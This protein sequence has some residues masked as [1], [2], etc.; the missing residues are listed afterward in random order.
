MEVSEILSSLRQGNFR[1][2]YDSLNIE[3]I[4]REA[5]MILNSDDEYVKAHLIDELCDLIMIGNITYNYSDMDALPIDDGVYDLLVSKLQRIDYDRFQSGASPVQIEM[6]NKMTSVS[7]DCI[8]P[9]NIMEGDDLEKKNSMLFTSIY[10][11]SMPY[12]INTNLEKPFITRDTGGDTISKRMRNTSHNYPDLVGTLKKCKFVLNKQALDLGVY[13]DTNVNILERDF[14]G[15]MFEKGIINNNQTLEFIISLKYDG[16]SIEADVDGEIISA[17]TRG[18]TD[19]NEASDLTPILGGYKFPNMPKLDKP[20]G[21]KF[22]AII[23]THHLAKLNELFGTNYINGRTAIIG[24]LGSSDA[25]VFRDFVTLVPL[26][27]DTGYPMT[28]LEEIEF[29]NKY[30]ATR[31]YFRYDIIRGTY[32]TALYQIK[33]YVEEAEFIRPWIDFMYDGVVL[34]FSDPT[35][36][37]ILG[38]KNSINLYAMAIKFNPLKR[39]TT[40]LGYTYT[41]GQNGAI[42][43]MINY[44]PVEFLGSIH[45]KSTGASYRRFKELNLFIGDKIEVTYVNDVMPYVTKPDIEFNRENHKRKISMKEQFPTTCPCCGHELVISDNQKSVYCP[46]LD[47]SDRVVKRLSNM[48]QKLGIK[49]FSQSTISLLK[50]NHLWELMET[51]LDELSILGPTSSVKF[52]NELNYLKIHPLP[53]YMIIGAL[54]FSNIASK[55]WKLIFQNIPLVQFY[56]KWKEDPLELKYLITNIKGAGPITADIIVDEFEYFAPDIEYIIHN[57]M[58]IPTPPQSDQPVLQIRFSGFRDKEL[59]ESLNLLP[60]VDCSDGGVTKQTNILLVPYHGFESS[61]TVK[62]IKYGVQIMTLQEFT[63]KAKEIGLTGLG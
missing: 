26:Q 40:F 60:N 3:L 32:T 59:E 57:N 20:I 24:I 50:K 8:K 37:N 27:V 13:N 9:F 22:E 45:T 1:P 19:I 6:N 47:C 38:R 4:S 31:E 28:R 55:K 46:N 63:D 18:D 54:G 12:N 52:Y 34:E 42:T 15:P 58:Y 21:V 35:I 53:D 36:R 44:A 39:L 49:D 23:L 30:I 43:P 61:K 10:D 48:I 62:A 41:V 51:T 5:T 16:V 33:K 17:R 56:S 14:F 7:N 2:I 11:M 25:R 29:M